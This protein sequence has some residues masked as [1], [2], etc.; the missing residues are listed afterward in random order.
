MAGSGSPRVATPSR[1]KRR[2]LVLGIVV[3]FVVGAYAA[4]SLY[5]RRP[6]FCNVCHE[7][8]PYYD[9]WQTGA[10][11]DV[12]CVECH[13]DPGPVADVLH[14]PYELREVWLHLTS[15]PTFP[16]TGAID[17]PDERCV[18]CHDSAIDPGIAGFDHETHRNG[19]T[20]KTCHSSAGHA[21]TADALQAAGI[22]NANA[23]AQ[24]DARN[25][26]TAGAGA[27]LEGHVAVPCSECHDMTTAACAACHEPPADHQAGA[28][29]ECH[30][31]GS[32]W[33]FSHTTRTDCTSCHTPPAGHF[34]AD[35]AQ[36]HTPGTAWSS[37][38]F[39]HPRIQGGEHTYKSFECAKCHPNGYTS[40]NCTCHGGKPPTD[41]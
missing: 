2:A 40:S 13:V 19:R 18:R 37:A 3:V 29:S 27:P 8:S 24:I 7:M 31:P 15:T 10:H 14:K 4:T 17:L 23:Q 20:C 21:V 9:A 38:D 25:A 6:A 16:L 33:T 36:C 28:C 5:T 35:C 32:T 1:W 22:L 11:A 26:I 30:A 39:S 41:D 12:P 34:E